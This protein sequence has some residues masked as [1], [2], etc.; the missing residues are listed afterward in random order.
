MSSEAQTEAQTEAQAE[1]Q[2]VE[3]LQ[4]PEIPG[5]SRE[6]VITLV[7]SAIMIIGLVF[8]MFFYM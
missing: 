8:C 4:Q 6:E 3:E 7:L 5:G 1:T 2:T